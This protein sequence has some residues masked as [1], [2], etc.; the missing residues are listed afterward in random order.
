MSQRYINNLKLKSKLLAVPNAGLPW[1]R[2][3]GSSFVQTG[4]YVF[5]QGIYLQHRE[6]FKNRYTRVVVG[7]HNILDFVANF[8][9]GKIKL[10]L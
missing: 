10:N 4:K 8:V 7:C 3:F 6:I 2:E 1:R 5:I 9:L